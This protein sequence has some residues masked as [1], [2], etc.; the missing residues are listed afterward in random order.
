MTELGNKS[1]ISDLKSSLNKRLDLNCW[2]YFKFNLH[3]VQVN[4]LKLF[5]IV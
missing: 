4:C 3:L 5:K 1:K 2:V